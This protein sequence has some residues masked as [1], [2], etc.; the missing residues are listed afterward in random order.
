MKRKHLPLA[1][2][3][4]VAL[5]GCAMK[6]KATKVPGPNHSYSPRVT[7]ADLI[8]AGARRVTGGWALNGQT[9]TCPGGGGYCSVTRSAD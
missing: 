4:V 6:P 1:I 7:E 5:S 9:W 2:A 3:I 8:A